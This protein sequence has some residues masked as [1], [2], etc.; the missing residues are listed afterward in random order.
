MLLFL[1][2]MRLSG[3]VSS[4]VFPGTLVRKRTSSVEDKQDGTAVPRVA[5]C[6]V[7]NILMVRNLFQWKEMKLKFICAFTEESNFQFE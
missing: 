5:G 7:V 1:P 4:N 3:S 6:W 2:K